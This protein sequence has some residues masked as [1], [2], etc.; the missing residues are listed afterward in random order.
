MNRTTA[1]GQGHR[2]PVL[3]AALVAVAV[4]VGAAP[5]QAQDEEGRVVSLSAGLSI[6]H[7][8]NVP[9]AENESAAPFFGADSLSDTYLKG[10][11]G[12][13]FDRLISQQRLQANAQVDGFKYNNYDNFDNIGYQAGVNYDWIIGRPFFGKIGGRI[14]RYQPLIQD[15]QALAG[16]TERNQIERQFVYLNGGVRLTPS[17]SAIVGVDFDRR[18]NSLDVF[19]PADNDVSAMEGGIRY[20]PGT[21]LELDLVYR[22]SRGDYLFLQT[23]TIN[24]EVLLTPVSNDYDQDAVLL[25]ATYRPSEDSRFTGVIG[26][27]KRNYDQFSDRDF[28]GITARADVEWALTGA[29]IMRVFLSNDIE[30]YD[31]VNVSSYTEATQFAIRPRIRATGRI[32][33]EPFLHYIDRKYSGE[34]SGTSASQRKDKL[35]LFGV[36]AQYELRRNLLLVGE[37]RRETRDS[38]FQGGDFSANVATMGVQAR[39]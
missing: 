17:F 38:N 23:L 13:N 29:T 14:Y 33:V 15:G 10:F 21:A 30:P 3:S 32:T 27:T 34:V 20:A 12:I 7:D 36:G 16:G 8:T 1:P 35:L 26:Q 6:T 31:G 18:R 39:F 28:D 5:A 24:G 11:V 2:L 19:K 9:R 22:R 37:L 25:R 4:A